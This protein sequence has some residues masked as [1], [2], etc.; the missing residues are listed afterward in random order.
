MPISDIL[1]I[2]SYKQDGSKWIEKDSPCKQ[3]SQGG[4][5]DLQ[6]PQKDARQ[7]NMNVK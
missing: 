7:V 1:E 5:H 3:K 4:G 2:W 6:Y